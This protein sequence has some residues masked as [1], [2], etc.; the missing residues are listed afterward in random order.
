MD[1]FLN[2]VKISDQVYWVGAIDWKVRNFHGYQTPRGTTYNAFLILDEKVTLIDT[3]KAPFTSELLAR[4]RSVIDPAKIDYIVSNHAEMDH[5]GA[6]PEVIKAVRPEKVF[7][8]VIG[9]K[10]LKAHFGESLE[11]TEVKTGDALKLGKRTLHFV[12][13]KMLHWPDSMFTYLD[14]EKILFSQDAFGM[15]M[16]GSQ[17]YADQYNPYV[18][19][20]EAKKY[21]A[22]ILLHLSPKVA[23]LL[24][25][26]PSFQF[27][28]AMIA[29]DHGPLYRRD[30][31]WIIDLYKK[32]SAQ[33]LGRKAMVM[34][35]TMWGSTE[36]IAGALLDGI[37]ST[38]VE[39]ELAPLAVLD[40]SAL[41]T[42]MLDCGIVAV[43][44]P[45]MNNQMFPAMADVLTYMKGLKPKNH[46]G[47]AFGSYGWSGE[48]AKNVQADL[49]ALGFEM[50]FEQ[51]FSVKYVPTVADLEKARN[52]GVELGRQLLAKLETNA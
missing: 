50:P 23:D 10:N 49:A 46:I 22:N 47:F 9:A 29:P 21:Y 1:E 4:I 16:A 13:T 7:A 6:L 42:K 48:G 40:R 31:N 37:V 12:E 14:T 26:L 39:A 15:H 34:Y 19:E 30:L 2:A 25:Q 52:A 44:T 33:P 3:V 27:E 18:L 36:K 32:Y 41:I 51:P 43:G 20:C 17:L 28:L 8:S 45:T 38:G 24:K 35:A 11:L 5:S